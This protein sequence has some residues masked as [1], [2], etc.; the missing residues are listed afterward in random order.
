LPRRTA[1][2]RLALLYSF[3]FLLS[4]TIVL[5]ITYALFAGSST[6]SVSIIGRH[7]SG[8][9]PSVVVVPS[10]PRRFV[11]PTTRL[12]TPV[13]AEHNADVG[14]LLGISWIVLA[15]ATL[16]SVPLG[17][18]AAGRM[19]SPLRSITKTAR[20]ISA[21]NLHERLALSGPDDEFKQLGDTLDDLLG[22]LEASFEAQRRFVANASHELRTPLTLERTLLQVALADPDASAATLRATCEELLASGAEHER[23][24]E[25]L[26]TLASGERGLELRFPLDLARIAD[27]VLRTARP[28]V[29]RLSLQVTSEL[30][31]APTFGDPALV[32]RLAANL[33]DNAVQHNLA[34]GHVS[35]RTETHEGRALLTV[36]NTG[37]VIPRDQVDRLLEPFQRLGAQ[38][39]SSGHE[40]HGLGLSIV[41][42]IASAHDA[43]LT[44]L[45]QAG[46][47]LAVTVSFPGPGA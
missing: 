27:Q 7:G 9:P 18:I 20:T 31:Q 2:L 34:A 3:M 45:P 23:L 5:A 24:L 39:T 26:L 22:R 37:P 46:G 10:P 1:R 21:G 14:R 16:A 19:L 15:L 42:A 29:E 8:A 4:G 36:T 38:R 6:I 30:G 28:E 44:V 40:G 13:L 12:V 43:S 11:V 41:R 35:V 25:S 32:E 33:I 17:W 47:G